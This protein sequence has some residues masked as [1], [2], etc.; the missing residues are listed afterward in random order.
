MTISSVTVSCLCLYCITYRFL[1][2]FS[3]LL[4]NMGF[5][6]QREF[7]NDSESRVY[8]RQRVEHF[9]LPITTD[10]YRHRGGVAHHAFYSQCGVRHLNVVCLFSIMF[11]LVVVELVSYWVGLGW[12]KIR[13]ENTCNEHTISQRLARRC[14]Y[15]WLESHQLVGETLWLKCFPT[16]SWS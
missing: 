1:G 10:T 7:R 4:I 14:V 2:A 8:Y 3:T 16:L 5:G 13:D 11:V 9:M 15:T 6:E 12:R